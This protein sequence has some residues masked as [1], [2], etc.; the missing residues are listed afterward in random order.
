MVSKVVEVLL[1]MGLECEAVV[2]IVVKKEV[3]VGDVV[4]IMVMVGEK[5]G[6]KWLW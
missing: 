1:V 3:K 5:F 6:R 4:E 2:I